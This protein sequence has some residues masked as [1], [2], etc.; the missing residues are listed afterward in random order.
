MKYLKES[1]WLLLLIGGGLII[2]SCN[3]QLTQQPY[4]G[5]TFSAAL[6]AVAGV[7]KA[8]DGN[9][10]RLINDG[11]YRNYTALILNF[12]EMPGDNVNMGT[13]TEDPLQHAFDYKRSKDMQNILVVWRNS[14]K[15]IYGANQAIQA[16]DKLMNKSGVSSG[17]KIKLKQLEG[18]NLFLRAK[19][20]FDLVRAF[21]RPYIQ[22]PSKNLGVP[23]VTKP[24]TNS[25]KP[26]ATVKEVYAQIVNDLK[27][28]ASLMT[29]PKSSSYASKEVAWAL[30][31]RVYLYMGE[32]QKVVAYSDSVINS[33]RYK[34]L[35]TSQ[36]TQMFSLNNEDN[37]EIIFATHMDKDQN[38]QFNSYASM[39]YTS[40]AGTGWGQM[41]ASKSIRDLLNEHP[42]DVRSKFI[43]PN[44]IIDSNGDTTG[45]NKLNGFPQY[46]ITKFTGQYGETMSTSPPYIRYAEMFLNR[47]EAYAK[48]GIKSKA[49]SDVN[50]IRKR[51]G[52]RDSAMYNAS[53]MNPKE[54]LNAVLR[55][56]RLEFYEEGFRAYD[57]YRNNRPLKRDYPSVVAG[58][59]TI[60]SNSFKIIYPIPQDV[61]ARNPKI[62]Q[63]PGYGG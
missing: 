18:E 57:I 33:N 26:R 3:D 39:Y 9:Y 50:R 45:I 10:G 46:F 56:R 21:G 36:Y 28:A 31:S 58:H 20:Y 14:Y 8:T 32:N 6:S 63:N 25:K 15:I 2:S 49:I 4:E 38:Q 55:E 24:N 16:A 34:L 51:A 48:M 62:K 61:I 52:I 27:K 59:L 42:H 29:D 7:K 44:Y 40:P 53:K 13:T 47:A 12:G 22:D 19:T 41:F 17:N 23:I 54:V 60:K 5:R 11:Y 35:S 30:L 43:K 37:P 1:K